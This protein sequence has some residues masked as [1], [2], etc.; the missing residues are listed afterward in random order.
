M[1][2]K[3]GEGAYCLLL[4][5]RA[6]GAEVTRRVKGIPGDELLA[7]NVGLT[8]C[9]E[10]HQDAVPGGSGSGNRSAHSEHVIVRMRGKDQDT[11]AW[12]GRVRGRDNASARSRH[13]PQE[14][15]LQV[16]VG[17]DH[18]SE[19]NSC[20]DAE[21]GEHLFGVL[22]RVP[23]PD[24]HVAASLAVFLLPGGGLIRNVLKPNKLRG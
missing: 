23:N 7:P 17:T 19:A 15:G 6:Q 11:R 13:A 4:A 10:Y 18:E 12:I 22:F 16:D 20:Q 14:R 21:S 1:D 8:T 2:A 24:R 9:Q 3:D 5:A